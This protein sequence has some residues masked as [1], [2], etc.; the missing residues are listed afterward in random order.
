MSSEVEKW[1]GQTDIRTLCDYEGFI[2]F[3]LEL[4]KGKIVPVL[5]LVR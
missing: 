3:P 2:M 5:N 4:G 1:V